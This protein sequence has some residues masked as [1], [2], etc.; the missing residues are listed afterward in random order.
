MLPTLTTYHCSLVPSPPSTTRSSTST[1]TSRFKKFSTSSPSSWST[2]DNNILPSK[3]KKG[4]VIGLNLD[5]STSLETT[6]STDARKT[7]AISYHRNQAEI[8]LPYL[9][10]ALDSKTSI[11]VLL[12]CASSVN[13][14][15]RNALNLLPHD[16]GSYVATAIKTLRGITKEKL[17]QAKITVIPFKDTVPESSG[18]KFEFQCLILDKITSTRNPFQPDQLPSTE[19]PEDFNLTPPNT[20]IDILIGCTD[21]FKLLKS[22]QQISPDVFVIKTK[23]GTT[24]AGKNSGKLIKTDLLTHIENHS[25]TNDQL[26]SLIKRYWTFERLPGDEVLDLTSDEYDAIEHMRKNTTYDPKTKRFTVRHIFKEEPKILNNVKQARGQWS[27]IEKKLL[28]DPTNAKLYAEHFREG[29]EAGI[30][31][32]VPE[33]EAARALD[34]STTGVHWLIHFPV[35]RP[36]HASTPC[37]PV[38][39]PSAPTPS[40]DITCPDIPDSSPATDKKQQ[41]KSRNYIRQKGRTLNDHILIGPNYLNSIPKL[42][43]SFRTGKYVVMADVKRQFHQL[44]IHPQDQCWGY[45]FYRDLLDDNAELKVFK[46][47]RT[48]FGL[49]CAPAQAAFCMRKIAEI[50][51]EKYPNDKLLQEAVL[52]LMNSN[53]ADDYLFSLDC[54]KYGINMVA[55]MQ[56][57]LGEGSFTL[58]KFV[59]NSKAILQSI[60]EH[61]R[62][63]LNQRDMKAYQDKE[64]PL[65]DDS[66]V[67]G[68][69]YSA[70]KDAF[71]LEYPDFKSLMSQNKNT[72]RTMLKILATLAYDVLGA[73]TPYVLKG[74]VLLQLSYKGYEKEVKEKT[75][76]GKTVTKKVMVPY[77]WDDTF[78]EPLLSKWQEYVSLIPQL[79]GFQLPRYLPL[80]YPY[81]IVVMSDASNTC[82]ASAA[83]LVWLEPGSSKKKPKY[84]SRLII[85]RG[86]VRA[87]KDKNSI[88]KAELD[89]VMLSRELILCIKDAFKCNFTVFRLFTDSMV[90]FH[91]V[92]QESNRL[93]V[94]QKNRVEKINELPVTVKYICSEMNGADKIAKTENPDYLKSE[95]YIRGLPWIRQDPDNYPDDGNILANELHKMSPTEKK[96]Y[97]EGFRSQQISVNLS[98]H[99][100]DINLVPF[101]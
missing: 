2:K 9:N 19:S 84:E 79:Q 38:F 85:T 76:N 17:Q 10:I 72:R 64:L 32:E 26:D 51:K 66:K 28:K 46:I 23:L 78:H 41:H 1:S 77:K 75:A 39:S 56:A 94:Y 93:G 61:L 49:R 57:I 44:L 97:L 42:T 50:Q 60:P 22:H 68:L 83:W 21:F 99:R 31:V 98:E 27:S 55:K 71:I 86:K 90:V 4:A 80:I 47:V 43:L 67:L 7:K 36:G 96:N 63:P 91:W 65:S 24:L 70:Q 88:A 20:K 5:G 54:E 25:V 34:P 35:L 12:D 29:L 40:P 81:T 53:Y 69:I 92:R 16:L 100:S 33:D 45:F 101:A 48:Y 18:Q 62:A 14:V 82:I 37:R 30:F 73:R 87:L 3:N 8:S 74:R 95:D 11:T 59:S 52:L 58:C 13:F 15:T 89:G 6:F